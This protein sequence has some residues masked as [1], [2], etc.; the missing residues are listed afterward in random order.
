[1]S[2]LAH[3]IDDFPI[4]GREI[5][6]HRLAYLDSAATT[7]KPTSVIKA[8]SD[9]YENTN[10][11]VHRG[12]HTLAHEATLAYEGGRAKVAEF[13]GAASPNEIV[14]TRGTS[15]AINLIA[16]GWGLRRLTSGD[17]IVITVQEHHSNIVPWQLITDLTGAELA[18]V[19]LNDDYT[20]DT[21]M[22]EKVI[23]ERTKI[24]GIS[25]MSNVTGAIGPVAEMTA[26]ARAVGAIVVMD[27]AQSVPHTSTAISELDVD[28]LAFSAHKMLGPTGIGALWGKPELFEEMSPVEGGGEMITDVGLYESRW[29]PVPHKFEAGTPAIAQAVGWG[30]A[31]DYLSKIGMDKVRRHEVEITKYALER[32]AEIPDLTVYGPTDLDKRGG[33]VSFELGDIHAHDL[34]TIL[35]EEGVAVR[36]GHHCAKPLMRYLE[37]PATAR[38]SF[39]VYT[40]KED[41]DQMVTA[42]WNARR[43]FGLD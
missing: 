14:F 39:Y 40:I 43:L 15:A 8:I 42:L 2:S 25:G 7:Q 34:A 18:Y 3:L 31:V 38:A 29:A 26:A 27:G 21:S 33:A 4:L 10:A 23:D 6:G 5:N 41:I 30:A 9:Y 35:D 24:V 11:N 17:R 32:M 20:V 28:F 22:L 12:A 36:A 16:Y 13:I 37:V 1:M 19:D